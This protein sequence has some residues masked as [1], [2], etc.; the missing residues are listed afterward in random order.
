MNQQRQAEKKL[1]DPSLHPAGRVYMKD[2]K[3]TD[4]EKLRLTQGVSVLLAPCQG[5]QDVRDALPESVVG[6][7]PQ[8]GSMSRMR[9][10]GWPFKDKPLQ[11]HAF[12]K[13]AEILG[14]YVANR[15]LY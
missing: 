3:Q 6:L 9:D 8:L 7:F 15:L 13:T 14:F 11:M 4:Q 2:L 10:P 12:E 1:L 5:L